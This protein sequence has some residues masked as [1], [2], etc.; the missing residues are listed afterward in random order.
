MEENLIVPLKY[1]RL[2]QKS[3]LA[4]LIPITSSLYYRQYDLTISKSIVWITTNL[5]WKRPINGWRRK[6]DITC[7]LLTTAHHLY[8]ARTLGCIYP[9]FV[10]LAASCYLL[11][12]YFYKKGGDHNIKISVYLHILLHVIAY[13]SNSVMYANLHSTF[14][15]KLMGKI[16]SSLVFCLYCDFYCDKDKV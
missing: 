15:I 5:Y 10:G 3:S 13:V 2:V 4:M 14:N 8:R 16:V 12:Y 1:A 11:S 9:V 7:V 6:I